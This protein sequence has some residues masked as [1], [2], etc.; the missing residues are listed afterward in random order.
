MDLTNKYFQCPASREVPKLIQMMKAGMNIAR[1]NFSHGTYDYHQGTID[2]VREAVRQLSAEY[3]VGE[4]P[5]G[6]ALDTKGPEIRTTRVISWRANT[7]SPTDLT[8]T[9]AIAAV[10][11]SLKCMASAIVVL[12]TTG[13]TAHLISKYRPRCPIIAVSRHAQTTRQAH[14][15]RGLLPIYFT[16][17]RAGDW[18]QDVDGRIQ[19]AIDFGKA[20]NFMRTGDS[21][22]VVTGWRKGPGSTNTMRIVTVE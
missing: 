1:M 6:I 21:V 19:A 22:I 13:R 4:H 14:L 7:P 15:W 10:N 20:R 5:V 3:G 8:T 18:P 11:A 17:E 2:N 9:M 12:T 16:G